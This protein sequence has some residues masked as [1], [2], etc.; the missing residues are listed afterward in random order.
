MKLEAFDN[1]TGKISIVYLKKT[2]E[3][4]MTHLIIIPFISGVNKDISY[5]MVQSTGNTSQYFHM[6]SIDGSIYLKQSLDRE[7][8]PQHH[9]TVIAR[10]KGL[11]SLSSTVHVWVKGIFIIYLLKY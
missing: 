4:T 3:N 7:T 8:I 6:D 9:F 10:D 1:D 2:I 5:I 11:P